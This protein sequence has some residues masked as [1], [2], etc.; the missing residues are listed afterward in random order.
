MTPST[1]RVRVDNTAATWDLSDERRLVQ[2]GSQ[3][4]RQEAGVESEQSV[5]QRQTIEVSPEE[6]H[7][8]IAVA[9]YYLAEQRGFLPGHEEN[10]WQ[11]AVLAIDH[12]LASMYRHGVSRED[13]QQ[14]GL[15][16]A[17]RLW[18]D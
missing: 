7:E 14:A 9:A 12:M 6:R 1:K 17:L 13:Y 5:Q 8:M 11:Q 15:K 3:C 10:D 4:N 16:N 2:F 18:V